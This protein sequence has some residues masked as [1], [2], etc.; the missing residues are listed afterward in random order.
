MVNFK[1]RYFMLLE[2]QTKHELATPAKDNFFLPTNKK[3]KLFEIFV[4][5]GQNENIRSNKY[6]FF[7][8]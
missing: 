7:F 3:S 4:S 2:R 6:D 8:S 5:I 1:G